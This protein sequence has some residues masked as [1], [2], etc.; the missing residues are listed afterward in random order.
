MYSTAKGKG[1]ST[2][3]VATLLLSKLNELPIILNLAHAQNKL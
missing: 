3:E 1:Y 2:L